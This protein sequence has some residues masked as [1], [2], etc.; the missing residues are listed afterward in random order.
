MVM[1]KK[2]SKPV[3]KV[4]KKSTSKKSPQ[5]I[6][7]LVKSAN[8]SKNIPFLPNISFA[9]MEPPDGFRAV[10]IAILENNREKNATF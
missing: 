2:P 7:K 1:D 3:S 10:S 4:L 9:D 8:S 5:K 6:L